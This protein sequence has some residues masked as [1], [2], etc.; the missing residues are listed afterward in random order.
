MSTL[1]WPRWMRAVV[2]SVIFAFMLVYTLDFLLGI[3]KSPYQWANDKISI[4][5]QKED[6]TM[7][8]PAERQALISSIRNFPQE[9]EILVGKYAETQLGVPVRN[10]E[11]TIRQIVHHLADAHFNGFIRMKLVLTETKP[12]LK[13]Y[14]QD[15]WARLGDMKLPIQPSFAILQG[16]HARWA[17][18]L[19][20]LPE[21]SWERA[22]IH[23]ENG[24]VTL[25]NLLALYAGHG[26]THLEQIKQLQPAK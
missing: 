10:G 14:D 25:D 11:W 20:S 9:L 4:R 8:T 15:A 24:L 12:I 17:T 5:F 7:S 1:I 22:G 19:A 3:I 13:P 26:Q 21:S 18:L 2:L 16:L 23:L 6:D